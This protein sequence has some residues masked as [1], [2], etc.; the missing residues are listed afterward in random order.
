M[1]Q[2]QKPQTRHGPGAYC[3]SNTLCAQISIAYIAQARPTML[4]HFSLV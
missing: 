3:T 4:L 1:P 2:K